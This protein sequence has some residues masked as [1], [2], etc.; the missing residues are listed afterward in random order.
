MIELI[1]KFCNKKYLVKKWRKDKSKFCST[2]CNAKYNYKK[3]LGKIDHSHLIG[4]K[5]RQGYPAS[6]P[7][8][9]GYT[10]WNKGKKGIH[11]SPK[12]EFK[13]GRDKEMIKADLIFHETI[14]SST[15]NPILEKT[16]KNISSSRCL[17]FFNAMKSRLMFTEEVGEQLRMIADAIKYR[18]PEAAGR[19]CAAHV[20]YFMNELKAKLL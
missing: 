16:I 5:H 10:P 20:Q 12:T 17:R 6:N 11:L 19:Y 7:F 3:R 1:C 2:S 9:K 8:K 13:K 15:E 18:E 4:N 14:Y